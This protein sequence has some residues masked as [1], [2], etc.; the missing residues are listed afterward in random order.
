M[1][2]KSLS[3]IFCLQL[4]PSLVLLLKVTVLE[5]YRV[6]FYCFPSTSFLSQTLTGENSSVRVPSL[7]GRTVAWLKEVETNQFRKS[8]AS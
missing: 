8:A 5:Q 3:E 1:L 6:G 4:I 7:K 2:I